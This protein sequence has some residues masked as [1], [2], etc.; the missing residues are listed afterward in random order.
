MTDQTDP[1][2]K[3]FEARIRGLLELLGYRV[4]HDRLV[5]G[6]QTDLVAVKDVFPGR[7]LYLVECKDSQMIFG[8]GRCVI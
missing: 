5:A 6:R 7:L 2:G 8:W 4:Q 1:T 3:T